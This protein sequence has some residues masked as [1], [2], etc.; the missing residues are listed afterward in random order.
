M[1]YKIFKD[2]KE[3]RVYRESKRFTNKDL[4]DL[5]NSHKILYLRGSSIAVWVDNLD[6]SFQVAHIM[7]EKGGCLIWSKESDLSFDMKL[8]DS[9]V[10]TLKILTTK[11]S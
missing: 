10:G 3:I 4:D 2:E 6:G 1:G 8:L 11:T 7:E 9:Y 5:W